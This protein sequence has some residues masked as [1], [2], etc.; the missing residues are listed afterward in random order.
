MAQLKFRCLLAYHLIQL[1]LLESFAVGVLTG[2][3]GNPAVF[4]MPPIAEPMLLALINDYVDKRGKYKS[5]TVPRA[6]FITSKNALMSALDTLAAY[7]NTVANND[8]TIITLAGYQSTKGNL[9]PINPPGQPQ[10]VVISRGLSGE[11]N[12]DCAVLPEADSYG[13]LLLNTELP[14]GFSITAS[15]Q[16]ISDGNSAPPASPS[17]GNTFIIIDLNKTR[18]KKFTGLQVGTTYYVYYWAANAGGVSPLSEV[19]SRKVVEV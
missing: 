6:T 1:D 15:G 4:T 3:F 10:Q 13:A 19:V 8:A 11:L 9:S 16:M 14:A 18:R 12:T 5:R 2:I 7:V 17:S